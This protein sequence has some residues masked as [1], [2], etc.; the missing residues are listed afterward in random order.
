[1]TDQELANEIANGII[2]TGVE[3]GFDGVSCSTAG[4]YPSMGVSQWEGIEGRGDALLGMIPGGEKFIGRSYL[5]IE[6]SDELDELS[7]LLDSPEGQEAQRNLLAEDCLAM[8]VPTLKKVENLDDSRCFIYA[9]IWCPTSHNTVKTFLRN[10]EYSFDIRKLSVIRD[11]FRD[12][13]AIAAGVGQEYADGYANRAENT[14]NY[15]SGL[16]LT[17]KYGIEEYD[18]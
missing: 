14:F 1:M 12:E 17:T 4:D 11:I 18:G 7:E 16:D 15:V 2:E 3:S 13:Y 8:Y 9:G 5:D 10:R 6:N